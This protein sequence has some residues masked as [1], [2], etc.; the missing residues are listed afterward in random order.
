MCAASPRRSLGPVAGDRSALVGLLLF[1]LVAAAPTVTFW[2]A[3]QVV[4]RLLGAIADRRAERRPPTPGPSL[5]RVVADVRRLHREVRA[6]RAT[7]RV[8]QVAL[9]AAYDDALLTACTVVGVP[10][11]PLA[12]AAERDRAFARLLTEAAL[13][14]AG[15]ALDPPRGGTRAA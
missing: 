4:P 7:S 8:R 14:E 12:G 13:E 11:P 10:D 15:V 3:L 1:V 9:L 2:L 5:E 6:G